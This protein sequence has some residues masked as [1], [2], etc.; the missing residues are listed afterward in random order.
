MLPQ[1]VTDLLACGVAKKQVSDKGT[2]V[3]ADGLMVTKP[4]L[5]SCAKQVRVRN[6][7]K[8][9]GQKVGFRVRVRVRVRVS[10]CSEP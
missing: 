8:G 3:I 5:H 7:E 1:T 4:H 10:P 6:L 9:I 2:C